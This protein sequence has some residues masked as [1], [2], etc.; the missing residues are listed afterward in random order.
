M[1]YYFDNDGNLYFNN[2]ESN[3]I[4]EW[5][6]KFPEVKFID[7]VFIEYKDG[8]SELLKHLYFDNSRLFSIDWSEVASCSE[9]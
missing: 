1:S 8:T 6:V 5:N 3:K 2:N 7:K 4:N 9:V